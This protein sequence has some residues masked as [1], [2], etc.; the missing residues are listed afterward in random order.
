LRAS[1]DWQGISPIA[2]AMRAADAQRLEAGIGYG[3][4]ASL[5]AAVGFAGF[6]AAAMILGRTGMVAVGTVSAMAA[7]PMALL[8]LRVLGGG[9]RPF[10]Q[11]PFEMAD[12]EPILDLDELVLTDADRLQPA[13]GDEALVLEDVLAEIA[14]DSRVVRLFDPSAMPTPAELKGR[15]DR[16]A[17]G[18]LPQPPPPDAS[19]ALFAALAELRRSLR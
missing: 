1:T 12:I 7:Y 3:A 18:G 11:P 14:P 13:A 16:H 17:H 10:S 5:A 4:A 15:I 8:L 9:P 19:D 2:V 6:H